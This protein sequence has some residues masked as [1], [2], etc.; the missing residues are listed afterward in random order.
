MDGLEMKYHI[1]FCDTVIMPDGSKVKV[2]DLHFHEPKHEYDIGTRHHHGRARQIP[3]SEDAEKFLEDYMV[4]GNFV[5]ILE[6]GES[7]YRYNN[8]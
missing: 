2:S 3:E 6:V 1:M 5:K 7:T 4:E 8:K